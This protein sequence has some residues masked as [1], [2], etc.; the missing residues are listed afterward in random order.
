MP[1]I[2]QLQFLRGLDAITLQMDQQFL[3]Y[4][5][6]LTDFL[7][8]LKNIIINFRINIKNRA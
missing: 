6:M 7:N 8:L 5:N 4:R 1:Y 3:D 2:T